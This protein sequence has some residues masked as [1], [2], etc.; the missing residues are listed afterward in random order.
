MPP[1]LLERFSRRGSVRAVGFVILAL[2]CFAACSDAE[3]GGGDAPDVDDDSTIGT[4]DTG[5]VRDIDR[6]D[7]EDTREDDAEA[8]T[9]AGTDVDAEPACGTLGC[10]CIDDRDCESGECIRAGL[11]DGRICSEICF[12]TCSLEGYECVV[13]SDGAD[14]TS[15]CVPSSDTYCAP[16]VR[17]SDCG[18]SRALCRQLPDGNACAPPCGDGCPS[19][20]SCERVTI[21]GETYD[22]CTPNAGVC[23]ECLDRDDDEYGLGDACLGEDCDDQNSSAYE[24]ATELCDEVD[25]DCDL[26]VDEDFDLLNDPTRCGSCTNACVTPN[27]TAACDNGT[28]AIAACDGEWADCNGDPSDGCEVD[29]SDPLLCGSCIAVDGVL[30]EDCGECASG[31]W[32][33]ADGGGTVC[34]GDLGSAARNACGGCAPIDGTPDDACGTC[35]SG[36]LV[37]N[38]LDALVCAGD[39]GTAARNA[40]GGCAPL[41]GIPATTCGTCNSGVWQCDAGNETVSC[42]GDLGDAARNACGGCADLGGTLGASCG[43]CS[44]GEFA[45][46]TVDRL[47]CEGDLGEDARNACGGCSTLTVDIGAACGGCGDGEYICSGVNAAVCSGDARADGDGDDVPDACD[48]CLAGDD[49][50]DHDGDGLPDACDCDALGCA[51]TADCEDDR[52]G[53][54]C[55][56]PPGYEGDGVVCTEIDECDRGTDNCSINADCTNTDGSFTCAC[57]DGFTGNGRECQDIDECDDDPCS[58]NATCANSI[59]S[60]RCTCAAGY[61]GDGFTCANVDECDR[62]SDNC[63]TNATCEDTL[64]SFTCECNEGYEGDGRS[65]ADVDECARGTDDCSPNASCSNEPGAFVCECN[66]GY[67][68]NGQTCTNVNECDLGSDN[69]STNATCSDTVGSFTCECNEGY[70]GD[71]RSCAEVNECER[72]TDAC[73]ANAACINLPGT[74]DCTCDDGYDGDGFACEDVNECD[75]APCDPNA[76]CEN[77]PGTFDCA[78]DEGYSGDGF[79]CT[80]DD[81]DYSGTYTLTPPLTHAC[82]DGFPAPYYSASTVTFT[83][84][85]T[86]LD[87]EGFEFE[88]FQQSDVPLLGTISFAGVFSAV[89]GITVVPCRHIYELDGAFVS[90]TRW[91]G[92]ITIRYEGDCSATTY[93]GCE[94]TTYSVSGSR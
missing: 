20:A 39:A 67:E 9:D 92:T 91:N 59:G 90:P 79:T 52:N 49:A 13:F 58:A 25:N 12:E 6:N 11:A 28:C 27:A 32:A 86:S 69:C 83:D 70:E 23:T 24:G 75:T 94:E 35:D 44:S 1:S 14:G 72:G 4:I 26:N 80:Y 19:G 73:D 40:C 30:G 64:G 87:V 29:L 17:D 81:V 56:C 31:V 57:R 41:D 51:P 38:G 78:C 50:D 7:V 43:T 18:S 88:L 85:G 16:C 76:T 34:E 21:G 62:G 22:V 5:G 68:G 60:F 33:C 3:P 89:G 53:A 8:D 82:G 37:C 54:S 42:V 55:G 63:S 84:G 45:C 2:A 48:L 74:Y 47:T 77:L 10:A 65:C 71:G 36:T 15:L 61:E 46:A 66:A 93:D